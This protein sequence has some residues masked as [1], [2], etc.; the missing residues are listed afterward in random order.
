MTMIDENI[1]ID[2]IDNDRMWRS[3]SMDEVFPLT[4][5]CFGINWI[6]FEKETGTIVE[7][8][9]HTLPF[10]PANP[11]FFIL[12]TRH[13]QNVSGHFDIIVP[14]AFVSGD[15]FVTMNVGQETSVY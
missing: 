6:L 1:N 15:D 8:M 10:I 2:D 11:C 5:E 4:A 12:W 7:Y 9:S 13:R 14:K 3:P